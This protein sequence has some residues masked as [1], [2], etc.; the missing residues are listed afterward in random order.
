MTDPPGLLILGRG[1]DGVVVAP[2]PETA[3]CSNGVPC[4]LVKMASVSPIARVWTF[5]KIH[6]KTDFPDAT[7]YA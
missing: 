4:L 5:L 6:R 3:V 1:M 2:F 7:R